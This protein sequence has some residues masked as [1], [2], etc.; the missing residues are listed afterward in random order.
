MRSFKKKRHEIIVFQEEIMR[1][2]STRDQ[3]RRSSL[4]KIFR[5]IIYDIKI[6]FLKKEFKGVKKSTGHSEQ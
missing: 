4:I 3:N 5:S 2:E 6:I 1:R